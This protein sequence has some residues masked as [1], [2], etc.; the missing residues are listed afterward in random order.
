MGVVALWYAGEGNTT[1][2]MRL[3]AFPISRQLLCAGTTQPVL[4]VVREVK[5]A[6]NLKVFFVALLTEVEGRVHTYEKGEI[7]EKMK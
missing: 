4:P 1:G 3:Q 7:G 6:V 5:N 2:N